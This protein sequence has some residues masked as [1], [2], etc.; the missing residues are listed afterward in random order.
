MKKKFFGFLIMVLMSYILC[1]E[2]LATTDIVNF[3]WDLGT[4]LSK[5]IVV[6]AGSN[7]T[8]NW[9]DGTIEQAPVTL[10]NNY[11]ETIL[12]HTYSEKSRYDASISAENIQKIEANAN[13]ILSIDVSGASSIKELKVSNNKISSLDLSNNLDLEILFCEGNG[14]SQL[15]IWSTKIKAL[16][17]NNNRISTLDVPNSIE[18]LYINSNNISTLDLSTFSNLVAL[19]CADNNLRNLSIG[20][21]NLLEKLDFTNNF[22]SSISLTNNVKLK[23]LYCNN[24]EIENLNLGNN[25]DL[26]KVDC[27]YNKIK[28]L[29]LSDNTKLKELYIFGNPNLSSVNLNN[30]DLELVVLDKDVVITNNGADSVIKLEISGDGGVIV[31]FN[32]SLVLSVVPYGVYVEGE[33]IAVEENVLDVSEFTGIKNLFIQFYVL[34]ANQDGNPNEPQLLEGM[35]PVKHDGTNWIITN[36]RDN[37]WY[38]YSTKRW[39]NVMLRDGAKYIDIDGVTLK[40][41]GNTP[42]DSL[43]GREVPEEN[44]GSMY[45]WIPRYSFK[46]ENNEVNTKYSEGLVDYTDEGYVLHPAFNYAK[47]KGGDTSNSSNYEELTSQDKYLGMWVAKYPAGNASVPKYASNVEEIRDFSVGEAFLKSKL[48]STTASYGLQG[49]TSHMMKN[50]E[51]GAVAYFTSSKGNIKKESTTGNKYGIYN[52]ND[53][54]EYVSTFIELIGGISNFNVRE[55]GKSLIPYAMLKYLYNPIVNSKDVDSIRLRKAQD[56]GGL[57][58]SVFSKYYGIAMN[59]VDVAISGIVT[60]SIPY[61]K[62]AFLIRGVDGLY[63]Y[64]NSSGAIDSDIGFRNVILGN[65]INNDDDSEYF[66]ITATSNYGGNMSPYGS[67][68]IKEGKNFIYSIKPNP[69]YEIVDVIVD[70][71]SEYYNNTNYINHGTYATYTFNNINSN[72]DIYIEFDNQLVPYNVSVKKYVVGVGENAGVATIEGIGQHNNRSIVTLKATP[73]TGYRISNWEIP[74]DL[75]NV[76]VSLLGELSFKMP[77]RDVEIKIN[78]EQIFD[79]A[80]TVENMYSSINITKDVGS[81]VSLTAGVIDGYKFGSWQTEGLELTEQQKKNPSI[82]FTMPANQVRLVAKYNKISPIN[83]ILGDGVLVEF[84]GEEMSNIK[85]LAPEISNSGSFGAWRI[86]GYVYLDLGRAVELTM[87]DKSIN[88]EAVYW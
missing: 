16:N 73:I 72:H 13:D 80:L 58:Y 25:V 19:E 18:E 81:Q 9:G 83:L 71:V 46:I 79:A 62:N 55:N 44:T 60:K 56:N 15:K 85:L 20:A 31:G 8:V 32:K 26:E 22:V 42:L 87:P 63:S 17:C 5:N 69:G 14:L 1:T 68:T 50:T 70:G 76:Q 28:T 77:S 49:G 21:N 57:N 27:T 78:F 43:I 53:D 59:E 39:A 37:G 88:I 67:I 36:A 2:S 48:V 82:E 7:I 24:N 40:D 6:G 12:A 30:L 74:S 35:I 84:E 11:G 51:W 23:E 66:T 61:E 3:S 34:V 41:V 10:T 65:G 86:D 38:N 4:S 64:S 47:Y 52:L 75:E 54:P 33:R 29:S 45:V